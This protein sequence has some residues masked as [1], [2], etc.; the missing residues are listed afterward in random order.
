MEIASVQYATDGEREG[1]REGEGEGEREEDRK[2][3]YSKGIGTGRCG[4][5]EA[6][7]V[8]D[9]KLLKCG[10]MQFETEETR[11]VT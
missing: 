10:S 11:T 5:S 9:G 1:S 4:L 3:E 8:G 2:R 6:L 7:P